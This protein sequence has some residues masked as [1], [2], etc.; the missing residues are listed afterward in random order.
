[1]T[2]KSDDL[3]ELVERGYRFAYAL[4][5]D[6]TRAD[7]LLQEAWLSV[8]KARG[9]WTREYLFAAIRNRFIDVCRRN[10]L[11]AFEPLRDTDRAALDS[12]NGGC[13]GDGDSATLDLG[14][15]GGALARLRHEERAVLYLTVV[16]EL[17]AQKVAE[18]FGWP[19]G[20]V[21][22]LAHRARKKL[23]EWIRL[24]PEAHT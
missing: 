19:R 1:M 23:R 18:M 17:T 12:E 7:D 16:E 20:T 10:A 4:V 22:S 21:L 2:S 13:E 15:L 8:L 9:P 14:A 3:C 24:E 5:H 11:V 6:G